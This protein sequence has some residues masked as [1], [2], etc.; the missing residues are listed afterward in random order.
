M[1]LLV[2]TDFSNNSKGAIKFA[3]TLAN[4]VDNVEVIFYHGVYVTRPT[5]WNDTFFRAYEE[6]EMQRLAK[7]LKKFVNGTIDKAESNFATTQFV[8]KSSISLEK[9]MI[10]FA[11]QHKVDF[12]CMAT[13]GA[14]LLRKIMGTHTSYIVNNSN[15]PVIVVPSH[16]KNKV[17]K[18]ATYLSD[19][20][21]LETELAKVLFISKAAAL[22]VEVLHY[23]S[24]VLDQEQFEYNSKLLSGKKYKNFHLNL[25]KEALELSL[26]DKITSYVQKTKPELLVMFTKRDKGFFES[27]FL[28]S[29]SAE[30][31]YTTRVPVLIFPK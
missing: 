7:E 29:K 3:Q 30:L 31:T 15:I 26:V 16:Y 24:V 14:G 20:E 11:E 28:P 25:K 2:T 1:K 8:V 9:D 6:E 17:L 19:F 4:Q 10:K 22:E 21:N 12:V 23:T 18:K 27:L 13:R 5:K